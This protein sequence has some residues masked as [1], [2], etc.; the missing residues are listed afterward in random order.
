M[1]KQKSIVKLPNLRDSFSLLPAPVAG[2]AMD[3]GGLIPV[4]HR[5]RLS[6]LSVSVAAADDFGSVKLCDLPS[7]NLL[8][9]GAVVEL[10]STQSGFTSNNGSAIDLAIGTAAT[11][12]TDFSGSNEK[13][14]VA[15]IDGTG[16]TAGSIKGGSVE[17]SVGVVA[18]AQGA[19]SV[20]INVADPVTSATGTI[21][22]SGYIDLIVVDLGAHA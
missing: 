13:N 22:L 4:K 16:T 21:L 14:L 11:A 3:V 8:I 7:D 9:L 10:T 2:V 15:K 20:Y 5:F 12:S 1:Q 18:L 19:K 6:G 17:G